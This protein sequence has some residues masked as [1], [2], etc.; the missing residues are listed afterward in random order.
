MSDPEKIDVL[1]QVISIT[2]RIREAIDPAVV[3]ARVRRRNELAHEER[4]RAASRDTRIGIPTGPEMI[5]RALDK[6]T[7]VVAGICREAYRFARGSKA[8]RTCTLWLVGPPGTGKTTSAVRMVLHHEAI[9]R[10]A[11]YVRAPVLPSVRN[12]A[13]QELYDRVRRT[14]LLVVDEIGLE[15]DAGTIT[16]LVCERHDLERFTVL[17]GNLSVEQTVERY[18]LMADP[19]VRSRMRQLTGQ[20]FK[21]VRLAQDRDYREGGR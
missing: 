6:G 9:G 1:A 3:E 15:A 5:A 19:R 11:A 14:D 4:M 20:G 12:Y 17:V 7:G 18:K 16:S 8:R 21:P 13:S 2:S 10:S